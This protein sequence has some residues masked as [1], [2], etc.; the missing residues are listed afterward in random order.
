VRT[1]PI[2]NQH[3]YAVTHV[4]DRG[5]VPA[6][7][8]DNWTV[9]GLNNFRQNVQGAGV[10]NAPNLTVELDVVA[11]CG[12]REV[13]LSA[14]VRNVGSRGVPAG[15]PV[16]FVQTAPAPET[17]VAVT[18]TTRP[19]LPGGSERVTV[20]AREQ[21]YDT[22]LA[23]VVRVDGDEATGTIA[24]CNEGD[25]EAGGTERCSGLN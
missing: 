2:W 16:E 21:P 22:E 8:P 20:V 6:T 10:F 9:P 19:L 14:L 17:V 7:P 24:E 13:R 18:S 11:A 12:R 15:V 3:A 1:R 25:N 5:N 4:D 23:F